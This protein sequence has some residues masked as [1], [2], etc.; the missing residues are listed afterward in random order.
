MT[1]SRRGGLVVDDDPAVRTGTAGV[2]QDTLQDD[3]LLALLAREIERRDARRRQAATERRNLAGAALPFLGLGGAVRNAARKLAQSATPILLLGEPG[4]G[5]KLLARWL[6]E[7]GP[8]FAGAFVEIPRA[9]FSGESLERELF[10]LEGETGLLTRAHRGTLFVHEIADLGPELQLRLLAVLEKMDVRLIAATLHNLG[11]MVNEGRFHAE[12]YFRSETVPLHVPP[13]RERRRDIPVIASVL[14]ETLAADL[15]RGGVELTP[16]ALAALQG[17]RWP[18]NVRE[19]CQVLEG[20]V[21]RS[22]NGRVDI[23][24]LRLSVDG[25]PVPGRVTASRAP[26]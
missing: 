13:L 14:A 15:G 12:L 1:R 17:H 2:L 10:G 23:G 9:A 16:S 22:E 4:T 20:A 7:N 19:L 18:G 5:K 21:R 25:Q 24:D 3:P 6:H 26:R 11:E 8:R